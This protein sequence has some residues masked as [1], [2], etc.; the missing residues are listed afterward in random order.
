MNLF[1]VGE[2][3]L[4]QGI[5]QSC[6]EHKDLNVLSEHKPGATHLIWI[7]HDTP[8]LEN[9]SPDGEWLWEKT[10]AAI[11]GTSCP[12]LVSSQVP[13]GF[14]AQLKTKRPQNAL[15]Y[16]PENIRA[17]HAYE[18]FRQQPRIVLGCDEDG[19]YIE[20]FRAVL[21]HFTPYVFITNVA[22]AEMIKHAINGFL[23]MSVAYANEL[24]ALCKTTGASMHDVTIGLRS[25]PRIGQ[26]AYLA[27][28]GPYGSHLEREIYNLRELGG[29]YLI[30]GIHESNEARKKA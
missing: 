16:S 4:A 30:K 11:G 1:I 9:N 22:S 25:D 10:I 18:D 26:K 23:A 7:A 21:Q 6:A 15:A 17:A 12:V 19:Q 2:G 28:G 8:I 29:G 27:E 13:P 5:R 24:G 3:T 20:L 14:M